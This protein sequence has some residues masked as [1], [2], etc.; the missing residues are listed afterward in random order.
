MNFFA[1]PSLAIG[2]GA[3]FIC[4]ET[5]LHFG[6]IV[7]L[8][9]DSMPFHDWVVSLFLIYGA[10]KNRTDWVDGRPYQAVG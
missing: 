5:C 2:F 6:N 4:A 8:E 7:S 10:M 1:R 9:W 3:F